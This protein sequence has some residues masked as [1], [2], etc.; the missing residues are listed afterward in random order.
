MV[1]IRAR[2]GYARILQLV[3]VGLLLAQPVSAATWQW[4]SQAGGRER[5]EVRL[6]PGQREQATVRTGPTGVELQF[7]NDVSGITR[8]GAAL[9]SGLITG[10]TPDNNSLRLSLRDPAFG[11]IVQRRNNTITLEVFP[12]Q[13]G[14]RWQPSDART[15]P[16]APPAPVPASATTPPAAGAASPAQPTRQTPPQPAQAP[17]AQGA[18]PTQ[19]PAQTPAQAPAQTPAAQTQGARGNGQTAMQSP[20]QPSAQAP[21]QS[22]VQAPVQAP[23]QGQAAA[24]AAGQ[25]PRQASPQATA[26]PSAPSGTSSPAQPGAQAPTAAQPG[27]PARNGQGAVSGQIDVPPTAP[28]SVIRQSVVQVS[29]QGGGTTVVVNTATPIGMPGAETHADATGPIAVASGSALPVRSDPPA[30]GMP[31][32][33]ALGAI[34]RKIESLPVQEET[35]PATA[36]LNGALLSTPT[37]PP[38]APEKPQTPEPPALLATEPAPAAEPAVAPAPEPAAGQ[39]LIADTGSGLRARVN[40][41]GPEA[42]PEDAALSSA[43]PAPPQDVKAVTGAIQ[44]ISESEKAA[45]KVEGKKESAA[46]PEEKAPEVVYVDE[47]GNPVPKPVDVA[48]Q[49]AEARK[50]LQTLQFEPARALLESLKATPM[51]PEKREELLYLLSDAITGL[52]NGKWLEGYE[53]IVKSTSEAMNANLRSPQVARALERLG[54]INLR[55]GNQQD[56][57]GYFA[58]LHSKFPTDPQVPES[59]YALGMDQLKNG[60]YAEAVQSFQRVM[61]EYP[62]SPAVRRAARYMAEALYKQG[63]Y[64]RALTIIDFVDRRWPRIYIDDPAYLL[65]VADTQFRRG[66]LEDALQTYWIYYNL[67]PDGPTNDQLL[68]NV[69]TI[70]LMLGDLEAARTIYAELLRRYP[71]S[72]Y[73]PLAVLRQGEEGIFEGNLPIDNLFAMFNRPDLST[74]PEVAYRRLLKDY[75]TSPEAVTAAFRLAVWKLWN[76]EYS[77]AMIAA[78]DFLKQYPN[79]IYAPRA[80]EIILRAFEVELAMDLAEQNYNRILQRWERFPQ[81]RGAYTPMDDELRVALARAYIN[82]GDEDKGFAL[83]APFLDRPQDPKYGDYVYQLNLARALRAQNWQGIL[84]L[85]KQVENWKLPQ[86]ERNQLIYAMATA[87]ENLG[88][89]QEAVPLWEKL[90]TRDDIP[91]YQKAYATY[92]MARDAE[93]RRSISDAYKLNRDTH[94]LFKRL[95]VE[96]PDRADPARIAESLIALMDVTEVANRFAE[97]LEWAEQYAPFVPESSPE[98]S[99]FQFRLARLHRK[100]G[101][102]AKWQYLL[103]D[104]IKRE[105]DSVFGR[106]AASELRTQE[107]ARDLSRFKQ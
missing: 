82:R 21:V 36:P 75:P 70:Y 28:S 37:M 30:A 107:V 16:P 17:V 9:G 58:I 24:P 65:M 102:L 33:D 63:H 106:M 50:L 49:L 84:D 95:D 41:Q 69:G 5:L 54:M 99:A 100:M 105:P 98:Y 19:T 26:S 90:Y 59:Y 76:Q 8:Q 48:A 79:S 43:P 73:A 86:D 77:D 45:A 20:A 11:Y 60:Q 71:N 88:Q 66:R 31:S 14:A 2:A 94:D 39:R 68:L 62:E 64:E 72:Q 56:A 74:L 46:K 4:S 47:A 3:V 38:A 23:V 101:D 7:N 93:R 34:T 44:P 6:D 83:L 81:I 85:G 53:P 10:V 104:I 52:Y 51:P 27:A 89:G 61:Q 78:E 91:L 42:W 40:L 97:A 15:L 25:P 32:N 55:T 103:N 1:N 18:T 22:P 12:D 87:Y 80:D 29:P 96:S 92:F 67:K 57:A 13:L 35:P